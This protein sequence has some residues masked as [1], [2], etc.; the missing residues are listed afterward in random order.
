MEGAQG[1]ERLDEG[2]QAVAPHRNVEGLLV[3]GDDQ[4]DALTSDDLAQ[5]VEESRRLLARRRD[6][7][8]ARDA[9]AGRGEMSAQALGHAHDVPRAMKGASQFESRRRAPAREKDVGH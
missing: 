4:V 6:E 1:P 7:E 5:R 3:D 9:A 2:G 8:I